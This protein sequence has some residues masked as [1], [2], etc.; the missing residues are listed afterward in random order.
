MATT[1]VSSTSSNP[2]S[3]IYAALNVTRESASSMED[4]QNRFL[5]LLTAQLQNQ[6][7]TSPMDSAQ[8]TSQLAQISTVDG[9]ERLNKTMQSLLGDS[10]AAQNLQAASLVGRGVLV[11]GNSMTWANGAGGFGVELAE[12]ADEVTAT[13]KDANGLVVRTLH[14]GSAESGIKVVPWD[15]KNDAGEQVADGNYKVSIAATRDSKEVKA[16][17]LSAVLVSGVIRTGTTMSVEASGA[18]YALD[19]IKGIV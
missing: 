13:I 4:I 16:E 7:P 8:M 12:P 3:D 19:S 5:T 10:Q 6:D 1:S 18:V 14:L 17:V 9:I 11:A 15:G 2:A